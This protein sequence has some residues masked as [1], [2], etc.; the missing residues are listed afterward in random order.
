MNDLETMWEGLV[1][2]RVVEPVVSLPRRV[3]IAEAQEKLLCPIFRRAGYLPSTRHK[4][5]NTARYCE[6]I[7]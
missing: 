3:A 7:Y 4:S 5:Y 1:T 2:V 6:F